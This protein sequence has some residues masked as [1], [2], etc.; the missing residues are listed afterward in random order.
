M[1]PGMEM[2]AEDVDTDENGVEEMVEGIMDIL[3]MVKDAANRAEIAEYVWPDLEEEG[4]AMTKE[5]FMAK[6]TGEEM[7]AKEEM[8]EEEMAEE[9]MNDEMEPVK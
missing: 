9:D 1:M 6:V 4:V 8:E 5:E 2:D 7:P 3:M